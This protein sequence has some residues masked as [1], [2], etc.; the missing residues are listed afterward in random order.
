M[1]VVLSQLGSGARKSGEEELPDTLTIEGTIGAYLGIDKDMQQTMRS[2]TEIRRKRRRG[3]DPIIPA[4]MS[5]YDI[6]GTPVRVRF[7]MTKKTQKMLKRYGIDKKTLTIS[8]IFPVRSPLAHYTIDIDVESKRVVGF[9]RAIVLDRVEKLTQV[10]VRKWLEAWVGRTEKCNANPK[11]KWVKQ[12][13]LKFFPVKIGRDNPVNATVMLNLP[14]G[15]LSSALRDELLHGIF[16]PIEY[17]KLA[18]IFRDYDLLTLSVP[19]WLALWTEI[20]ANPIVACLSS[21]LKRY[22]RPAVVDKLMRDDELARRMGGVRELGRI[23]DKPWDAL[24]EHA[25]ELDVALHKGIKYGNTVTF[26]KKE[27]RDKW[28]KCR[29]VFWPLAEHRKNKIHVDMR[30]ADEAP[31]VTYDSIYNDEKA[32]AEHLLKFILG[33]VVPVDKLKRPTYAINM[34][35]TDIHIAFKLVNQKFIVCPM[36]SATC[37]GRLRTPLEML[38]RYATSVKMPAQSILVVG[39]RIDASVGELDN[40][41]LDPACITF[42]HPD[43]MH[44]DMPHV[45][46][47]VIL[48]AHRISSLRLARIFKKCP[49]ATHVAVV[50]DPACCTQFGTGWFRHVA[51]HWRLRPWHM[52]PNTVLAER[53]LF[54][55]THYDTLA[56]QWIDALIDQ[57]H[58]NDMHTAYMCQ[59]TKADLTIVKQTAIKG[60]QATVCPP[61]AQLVMDPAGIN[62]LFHDAPDTPVAFIKTEKFNVQ[63]LAAALRRDGSPWRLHTSSFKGMRHAQEELGM[64]Q[65][66]LTLGDTIVYDHQLYQITH[67]EKHVHL[68]DGRASKHPRDVLLNYKIEKCTSTKLRDRELFFQHASVFVHA[69]H[70][71]T[72]KI[73]KFYAQKWSGTVMRYGGDPVVLGG[74]PDTDADRWHMTLGT[75]I[76]AS[77]AQCAQPCHTIALVLD[78]ETTFDDI[79]LACTMAIERIVFV[80]DGATE[81][82]TSLARLGRAPSTYLSLELARLLQE[83]KLGETFTRGKRANVDLDDLIDDSLYMDAVLVDSSFDDLLSS[84]DFDF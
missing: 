57:A 3:E 10:Y 77:N 74:E 17:S 6:P 2:N 13:I 76:K 51:T 1:Q 66:M 49:N 52:Q 7:E 72:N 47:L 39:D 46:R 4:D 23:L 12:N 78:A 41:L 48:N 26:L 21:V 35:D 84:L 8:G 16:R 80:C 45:Q 27:Q 55:A 59:F 43:A 25:V 56:Y 29:V 75:Q 38:D 37:A 68:L 31:I 18:L 58:F 61:L 30:T 81:W 20:T 24:H 83:N 9:P 42:R 32:V 79:W 19:Q 70:V 34:D 22:F 54:S 67:M 50:G 28:D 15:W 36:P 62:R 64:P 11:T 40:A 44:R 60:R 53:M 33:R 14:S 69:T 5:A 82:F 73:I 71:E 65:D 63:T